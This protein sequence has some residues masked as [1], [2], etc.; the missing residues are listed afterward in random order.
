MLLSCNK[1][2]LLLQKYCTGPSNNL[3]RLIESNPKNWVLYM[4]FDRFLLAVES[5]DLSQADKKIIRVSSF[6]ILQTFNF[7]MIK[8]TVIQIKTIWHFAIGVLVSFIIQ[9]LARL[10]SKHF[11][12]FFC[13]EVNLR[14]LRGFILQKVQASVVERQKKKVCYPSLSFGKED[15]LIILLSAW[16]RSRDSTA[17]R[18]LSKDM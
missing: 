3:I 1:E 10:K 12:Q 4:S 5:R 14:G 16:D 17:K 15:S 6:S 9:K 2:K 18:N 7:W 11:S 13:W 8:F